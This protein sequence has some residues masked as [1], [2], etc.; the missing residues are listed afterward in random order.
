MNETRARKMA[1]EWIDHVSNVYVADI[2]DYVDE[3]ELI[4]LLLRATEQQRV[5]SLEEAARVCEG[6]IESV[7]VSQSDPETIRGYFY[8]DECAA[9]IRS[10]KEKPTC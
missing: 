9:A 8:S 4:A 1:R 7:V 2:A 5:E 6:L 3:D 10:A